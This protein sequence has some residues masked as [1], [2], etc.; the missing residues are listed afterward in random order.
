MKDRNVLVTGGSGGLGGAV[1][2]A[3]VRVGA[4]V[5]VPARGAVV[6]GAKQ[7]APVDVTDEE[8]VR[9]LFAALP[10]LWASV[11]VVGGFLMRPLVETSLADLRGQ[12]DV[13][14]ASAFLC[15]REAARAMKQSGG[16]R[17]INVASQ[18]ALRPG[19]AVAAY[20]AS[21]A[22]V[23]A[24]TQSAAAELRTDGILVNAVA[25]GTIDTP[26]NRAAMPHASREGWVTPKQIAETILWLCSAENEAVT[27]TVTSLGG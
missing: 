24:L 10:P 11:H 6:A 5:H 23:V 22:A 18:A 21:K 8:A 7:L 19:P 17:I 27:G 13:N 4:V 9:A 3:F 12:L 1:V 2:E 25:P 26:A 20:A 14:L 16:G 15:T